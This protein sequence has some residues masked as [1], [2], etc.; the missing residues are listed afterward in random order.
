MVVRVAQHCGQFGYG[1]GR[2]LAARSG[3]VVDL[4]DTDPPR[5][6]GSVEGY[7]A[8]LCEHYGPGAVVPVEQAA[9]PLDPAPTP[10]APSPAPDEATPAKPKRKRKPR[11]RKPKAE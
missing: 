11:A 8:Y 4:T 9:L 1:P 5:M 2:R 7:V 10:P 3:D 6:C